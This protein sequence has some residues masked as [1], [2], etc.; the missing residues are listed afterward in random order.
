L[1][2]VIATNVQ[3]VRLSKANEIMYLGMV[4]HC[5]NDG[6]NNLVHQMKDWNEM[7][8]QHGIIHKKRVHE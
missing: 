6:L 2:R 4:F 1:L 3:G 7:M 5:V 8:F